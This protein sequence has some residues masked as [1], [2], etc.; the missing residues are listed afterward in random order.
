MKQLLLTC[1]IIA[2]S[3]LTATAESIDMIGGPDTSTQTIHHCGFLPVAPGIYTNTA[4]TTTIIEHK[5][6][7]L[8]FM[9]KASDGRYTSADKRAVRAFQADN[10]LRVDGIVGPITAQRLAYA[11][12]PSPNVK[13]CYRNAVPLR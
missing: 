1:A 9:H 6:M 5:L 11:S 2:L 10:N 12:H 4:V 8:G 3:P 13:R 7:K